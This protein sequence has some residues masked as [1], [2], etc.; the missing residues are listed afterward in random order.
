MTTIQEVKE[1]LKTASGPVARSLH[2]GSGYKFLLLGFLE[3]MI[4]KEHKANIRSKL[5]VLEGAVIY[6]EAGRKI[7]LEQY[8]EV[9]IP[10][11]VTHW[12]EALQ[13]SL[14]ILT[15]GD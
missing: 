8:E 6:R 2:Q 12:V 4:M 7:Q 9:D 1:K 3:G 11:G 14:C 10:V 13:D 15:Q 5:T